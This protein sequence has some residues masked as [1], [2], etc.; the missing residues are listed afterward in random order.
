MRGGDW[1]I[2]VTDNIS[3]LTRGRRVSCSERDRD[4][5][6]R[7]VAVYRTESGEL[8][9]AMVQRGGPSIAPIS[10]A[11]DTDQRNSKRAV[12]GWVFGLGGL[13]CLGNGGSDIVKK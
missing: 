10:A 3:E 2:G 8:N 9:S 13:I 5:Y 6:G 12:A 1:G 11:G 4:Q 7:I